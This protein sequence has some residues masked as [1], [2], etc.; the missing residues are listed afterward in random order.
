MEAV[1]ILFYQ[2]T[3]NI[4]IHGENVLLATLIT[5]RQINAT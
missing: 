5:P 3:F 1:E 2:V 4:E